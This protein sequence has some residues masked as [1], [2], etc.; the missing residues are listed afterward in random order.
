MLSI[1]WSN[2]EA[3]S[4]AFHLSPSREP[5]D[6]HQIRSRPRHHGSATYCTTSV[7]MHA[8]R[9]SSPLIWSHDGRRYRVYG[10]HQRDSPY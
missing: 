5:A 8:L 7:C 6:D 1:C 10:R 3:T 2:L 9:P 4:K